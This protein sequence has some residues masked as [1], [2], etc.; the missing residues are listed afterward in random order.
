MIENNTFILFAPPPLKKK[1]PS[2]YYIHFIWKAEFV[3][4]QNVFDLFLVVSPEIFILNATSIF[5]IHGV[6]FSISKKYNY[7]LL[8]SNVG[9]LDYLLLHALSTYFCMSYWII[10]LGLGFDNVNYLGMR[11]HSQWLTY[12]VG[13]WTRGYHIYFFFQFNFNPCFLCL[14][15]KELFF[16]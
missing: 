6:V 9:W 2:T 12:L 7:P 10:C 16:L 4:I 5:L 8:V 13:Y 1:K 15:H 14:N 3:Q 11:W